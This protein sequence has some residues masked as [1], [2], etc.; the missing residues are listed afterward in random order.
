MVAVYG[1]HVGKSSHAWY[2]K[3]AQPST[4]V[5]LSL[6]QLVQRL[7]VVNFLAKGGIVFCEIHWATKTKCDPKNEATK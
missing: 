6:L 5:G 4:R 3:W 1:F 2:G 7:G